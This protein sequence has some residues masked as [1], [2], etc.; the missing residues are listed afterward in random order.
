MNYVKLTAAALFFMFI[1]ANSYCGE[2]CT[3]SDLVKAVN[4]AAAL[5]NEKG[6]GALPELDKYRFCSKEGY[7]F[8]VEFDGKTILQ[9][10][11]PKLV[12]KDITVL[13]GAKGEYFGAEMKAK[14]QNDGEGWVSYVWENPNTKRLEIKCSYIKAATMDGQKVFVGS[15]IYGVPLSDCK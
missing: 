15:G 5:I 12:G 6:K 10:A 1:A 8:V 4:H 3:K 11:N 14:A 2:T 13:Q 7:I 9:P